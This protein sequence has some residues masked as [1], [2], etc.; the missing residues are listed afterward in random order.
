[1]AFKAPIDQHVGNSDAD[2][3][4]ELSE[5]DEQ[6]FNDDDN[7]SHRENLMLGVLLDNEQ[8]TR[9]NEQ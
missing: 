5:T 1:M 6:E 8:W 7:N 9:N 3:D 2:D 4:H